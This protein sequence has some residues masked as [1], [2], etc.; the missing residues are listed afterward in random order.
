[1]RRRGR[2]RNPPDLVI[3]NT[4]RGAEA[5]YHKASYPPYRRGEDGEEED[6][7]SEND[8]VYPYEQ[9][10]AVTHMNARVAAATQ[11]QQRIPFPNFTGFNGQDEGAESIIERL[12]ME[13]AGLRKQSAEAVSISLR[14]SDQLAGAQEEASRVRS[15][16][17]EAES[18]LESEARKR[19]DVL[20]EL[21]EA[22]RVAEN[23][24]RLRR[25]AEDELRA[26][27]GR[28]NGH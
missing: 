26:L 16:L 23:E 15:Q 3:P 14:L 20:A 11:H 9:R 24:S 6:Y 19:N 2:P 7:E 8:M 27:T 18:M 17:R 28:L 21:S 5:Y 4:I 10:D 25:T 22:K 13:I 12:Q 1:M